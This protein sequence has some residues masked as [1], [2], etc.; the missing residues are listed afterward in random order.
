MGLYMFCCQGLDLEVMK[1]DNK[2]R[3]HIQVSSFKVRHQTT[4]Q[5]SL[6]TI[7]FLYTQ[8]N[9]EVCQKLPILKKC[10]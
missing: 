7:A 5:V 4:Q 8:E 1:G 9:A 6:I 10:S 3:V 2:V